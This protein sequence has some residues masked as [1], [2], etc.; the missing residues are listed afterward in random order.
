[1]ASDETWL[2]FQLQ[3][4]RF[5]ELLAEAL[6]SGESSNGDAQISRGDIRAFAKGLLAATAEASALALINP[7]YRR[8]RHSNNWR[9]GGIS[10]AKNAFQNLILKTRSNW[11]APFMY[12]RGSCWLSLNWFD[13]RLVIGYAEAVFLIEKCDALNQNR[14]GKVASHPPSACYGLDIQDA[15]MAY[16]YAQNWSGPSAAFGPVHRPAW[17]ATRPTRGSVNKDEV[18]GRGGTNFLAE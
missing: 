16:R 17:A 10:S 8:Q 18:R 6:A 7:R 3:R 14:Q 9:S 1:M 12:W 5:G 13:D 11:V 2:E 4:S 15:E